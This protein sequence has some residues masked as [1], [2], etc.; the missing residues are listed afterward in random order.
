[1]PPKQVMF[2][3]AFDA[4]AAEIS[5]PSSFSAP[6]S[7]EMLQRKT[8]VPNGPAFRDQITPSDSALVSILYV[9]GAGDSVG[10]NEGELSRNIG[11][12]PLVPPYTRCYELPFLISFF[13][14]RAD[15]RSGWA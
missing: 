10:P 14:A 8:P 1:M 9:S 5:M 2:G 4:R 15:D 3:V 12:C 7:Q 13:A 6:P 11:A